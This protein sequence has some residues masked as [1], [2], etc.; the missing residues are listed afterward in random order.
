MVRRPALFAPHEAPFWDDPHIATQML[1]AHLDPETDAASRRPA[2]IDA[3]V[4]WIVE[5]LGLSA[6]D[7]VLDLGCGPGLYCQRLARLG[8]D[9]TGIDLSENSLLYAREQ[10]AAEGLPI[11]YIHAN[12]LTL[13]AAAEYDAA[14]LIYYD[15]GVLPDPDRDDLLRRVRRALRPAG[16]FVFDVLA[17]PAWPAGASAPRPL[18]R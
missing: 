4:A 14:L 16:A 8:L 9:V 1:A 10:A 6:G 5:Q 7:R 15:F 11:R 17:G 3:T 13:D 18:A 2:T 12:Y